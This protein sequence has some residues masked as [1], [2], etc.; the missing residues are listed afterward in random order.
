MRTTVLVPLHRSER[1]LPVVTENI[2]RLSTR[3]HV[4]VSDVDELDASLGILRDRFATSAAVT[5]VGARDVPRGWVAH[6]NELMGRARTPFAMWLPHD[7]TIELSWVTEAERALEARRD[8][9]AACGR[10]VSSPNSDEG[11]SVSLEPDARLGSRSRLRRLRRAVAHIERGD[12]ALLGVLFRSVMRTDRVPALP[13]TDAH[14]SWSDIYWALRLLGRGAA[15]TIEEDYAKTWHRASAVQQWRD[16]RDDREQL[17]RDI[18]LALSEI[19]LLER[20]IVRGRAPG[21]H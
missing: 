13:E 15:V 21:R 18:D 7:D 20:M 8:A 3:C 9:V 16:A 1:W 4:I 19:P 14:G 17:G 5:C 6:C 10:L 12:P 2:D 11:M